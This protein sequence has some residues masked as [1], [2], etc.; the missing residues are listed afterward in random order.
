MSGVLNQFTGMSTASLEAKLAD[1]LAA[2]E[3]MQNDDEGLGGGDPFEGILIRIDDLE[4]EIKR[5]AAIVAPTDGAV[6]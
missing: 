1:E 3:R 2:L 6:K 5:R 4:A